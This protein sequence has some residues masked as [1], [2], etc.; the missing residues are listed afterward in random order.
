MIMKNSTSNS[1]KNNNKNNEHKP[2][3]D[4]G[5]VVYKDKAG[6]TR[7]TDFVAR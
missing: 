5:E 2:N 6:K 7:P 1:S 3:R 4:K